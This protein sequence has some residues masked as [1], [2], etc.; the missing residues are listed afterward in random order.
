MTPGSV[1]SKRRTAVVGAAVV[2]VLLLVAYWSTQRV[3]FLNQPSVALS[4]SIRR[5]DLTA[6][7]GY[8]ASGGSPNAEVEIYG[9]R[10]T[11]LNEAILNRETAI[12]LALLDAG[13]DFASSGATMV[14]VAANGM[15]ELVDRL[16]P[17]AA[18][19]DVART[20]IGSA[21]GQ[22]RRLTNVTSVASNSCMSCWTLGRARLPLWCSQ[23]RC[24]I[25][26]KCSGCCVSTSQTFVG[27]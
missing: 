10:M 17:L 11:M 1:V 22:L 6:I 3:W 27:G 18:V 2:L 19:D 20:G 13:G 4:E 15:T 7:Q 14:E 5:G 23:V 24:C 26:R 9:Q 16:L 12:A 8:L 25:Q 21:A